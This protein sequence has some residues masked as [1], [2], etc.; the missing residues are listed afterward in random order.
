MQRVFD[1]FIT[2]GDLMQWYHA[3]E[4]WS[5]PYAS[6]DP[7]PGGR[8]KIGFNDPTGL[9]TFDFE[10]SFNRVEAPNYISYT[11]A[12]GRS[13]NITFKDRGGS[14]LIVEEFALET[15]NSEEKQRAGWSAQLQNLA[16]F[17]QREGF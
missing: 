12:D 17:L 14:T 6:V 10:G 1:A 15:E 16:D 11:I 3:S 4:G 8:F 13:V 2:E 7:F 5:T 9:K